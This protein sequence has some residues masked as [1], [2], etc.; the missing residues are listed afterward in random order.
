MRKLFLSLAAAAA[1]LTAGSIVSHA[2]AAGPAPAGLNRAIAD[3]AVVDKVH[4]VPGWRHHTPTRW[5]RANGCA[6]Y[7][8][9]GVTTY[10]HVTTYPFWGYRTGFYRHH[11]VVRIQRH[12][13]AHI[14]RSH[15]HYRR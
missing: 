7:Y 8:R 10:P 11:R 1:V 5:H 12:R 6:R 4:C 3:V 2:D 15:R 13:H 9:Y 14:H